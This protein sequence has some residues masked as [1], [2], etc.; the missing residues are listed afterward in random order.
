MA[1]KSWL[2]AC[3]LMARNAITFSVYQY[4]VLQFLLYGTCQEHES[5]CRV[6]LVEET[7]IHHEETVRK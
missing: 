5:G 7:E 1:V 3:S 2:L 4:F 6:C